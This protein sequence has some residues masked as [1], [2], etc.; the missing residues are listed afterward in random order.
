M[1][2]RDEQPYEAIERFHAVM[3]EICTKHCNEHIRNDQEGEKDEGEDHNHNSG[4]AVG[5]C[6]VYYALSQF[7]LP[8]F[9]E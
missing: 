6:L 9:L 5:M 7:N 3:K 1:T 8:F 4:S 2:V